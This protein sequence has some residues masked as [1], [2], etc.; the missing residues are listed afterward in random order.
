MFLKRIEMQGFKSFADRTVISFEHPITGVVGPNGCGKSNI[1]D[2]VRWVLGEQSAKSMRGE[3]MNDVIFAGSEDRRKVNMAEVTLVFDNANHILNDERDELEVTRRLYRDSGDAEYLINRNNVRLRDVV[4]LFLDTG[5]GRDSLSIISQGNVV[6]FAEAKPHDRRGIFEEAAG[7]AKY[8]KRKLESLS[9]LERT[10]AN[11]ERSQDILAELE[12]QVSP[13][14]RQAHK[15]EIYREKKKRL[16]EIEISVLVQDIEQIQSEIESAKKTLFDIETNTTMYNTSIQ[17]SETRIQENRRTVQK[18]DQEINL[19]QDELMRNISDVQALE[20]RRTE[21]DE[22]RKYIVETG[23]NEQKAKEL[24][25]LLDAARIEYEDRKERLDTLNR[26]IRLFAEKLNLA[27]QEIVDRSSALEQSNARLRNLE[28]RKNVLDQLMRNPFNNQAGI[29]S[30]MDNRHALNGIL[31]V[32]GQVLQVEAGYEEAISTA[33]G[34]AMNNIVTSDEQAARD[35]I[36]FLKRN[37]SGRATFLPINVCQPRYVSREN[38]II[39]E[40]TKGFLGI[41]SDFVSNDPK[42]DPVVASL[43]QNVLVV[44]SMEAGNELS[45]LTKRS[46]KIVTLD[47]EVIHRGGS[48]TGGKTRHDTNIVTMKKE[49]EELAV[50]LDAERARYEMARKAYDKATGAREDAARSLQEKRFAAAA[51]EPIVDAKQAKYEKLQNDYSLL[52]PQEGTEETDSHVD[53]LVVRL[54]AAYSRRDEITNDIKAKRDLR[55]QINQ[56]ADRKDAQLKQIRKELQTAEAAANA[57]RIDQGRLETRMENSLER[58]ASEYQLTFEFARTRASDTPVDNAREE[59]AQLRSDI[60]RLG[61]IN[62]NAPEEYNEVNERYETMKQQ[63]EELT[64]S[65]DKILAAIDEMDTVMKKQFKEMFDKINVQFND[66]FRNLY[67][68]GKARL[69]LQEPDDLLN[70]GIDIDAQPPGKA[71]QNNMLFSGGE[72]SLIALCVLFAILKVKPVPLV[73]LDEVEAALDPGN[74]E[75]F[76]QYL[77]NYTDRTQFIVVTHRPGTMENTDVLYGVT[78]QHQG[79]SQMLKVQLR[80]AINM[81]EPALEAA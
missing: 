43:L 79:V 50:S 14:K 49:A 44:E 25:D 62:M 17:I 24:R 41:A 55:M 69:I 11:L 10:A 29:R 39:C 5:L 9:K 71:V 65:R 2:A 38:Q 54:N 28:N 51:L 60:E 35:A 73:I 40:N 75:R 56:D 33:L 8:K 42:F 15:A 18:L 26:E 58:L 32:V 52:Q 36:R 72:K 47:G 34:G 1:A 4:E 19:L 59:V 77:H 57:I 48:M 22:R 23:T 3:K 64:L 30:I 66:I 46:Y 7:V 76:A 20:A 12:K 78:M 80:E 31:G 6:S 74:V 16:E 13:L 37:L 81:A 67:G 21:L 63:I 61:N 27:A 45:A 70:T 53:E 68:G